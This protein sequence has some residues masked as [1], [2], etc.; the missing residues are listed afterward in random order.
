MKPFLV[1]P[2]ILLALFWG[3]NPLKSQSLVFPDY[4]NE[5]EWNVFFRS[6][7][8]TPYIITYHVFGEFRKCGKDYT[9]IGKNYWEGLDTTLLI[10]T[11]EEKVFFTE[12][13]SDCDEKLL[14]NFGVEVG[15]EVMR[16]STYFNGE[17]YSID[18]LVVE[19]INDSIIYGIERKVFKLY[20]ES[21][22]VSDGS[23]FKSKPR[24]WIRGIGDAEDPFN[25]NMVFSPTM[26]EMEYFLTC[27]K[28]L[29]NLV[30]L[31]SKFQ[32]CMRMTDIDELYIQTDL[33]IFPNPSKGNVNIE[34]SRLKLN[35][36]KVQIFNQTGGLVF[37]KVFLN[38]Q[39]SLKLNNLPLNNGLYLLVL[40]DS[41]GNVFRKELLISN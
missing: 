31:N 2:V 36:Y 28:D 41:D 21:Y 9:R 24:F 3:Y 33:N 27:A 4:N 22:Y 32:D 23:K 29:D 18:K 8:S 37:N 1:F 11:E 5:F 25:S 40:E 6:Y 7:P 39:N 10:R 30:Y 26:L 15:E 14:Y 38:V 20:T 12:I 35:D 34:S 16:D 17:L 19:S 13:D